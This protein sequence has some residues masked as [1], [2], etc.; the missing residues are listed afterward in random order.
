MKTRSVHSV[1]QVLVGVMLVVLA[2]CSANKKEVKKS[3]EANP[4]STQVNSSAQPGQT[5]ETIGHEWTT[6]NA[7]KEVYFDYDKADLKSQA[8]TALKANVGTIRE[9]PDSAQIIVEGYCDE[10]GTIEY[11]VALGQRRADA[12]KD[13]YSHAGIAKS[14]LSTISY[15]KERPVCTDSTED[16]W[17]RNRR[18]VTRFKNDTPVTVNLQ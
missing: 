9:V 5:S 2:G 4:A 13:Y 11:N 18:D 17:S 12:V 1:S 7:V 3:E 6:L 10:R 14:R 15:G 8:L 16:C